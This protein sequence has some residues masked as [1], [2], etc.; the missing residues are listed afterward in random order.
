MWMRLTALSSARLDDRRRL[1]Y[2][3]RRAPPADGSSGIPSHDHELRNRLVHD[4]ASAHD[5]TPTDILHHNGVS[6]DPA[7]V[8]DRNALLP[9]LLQRHRNVGP[10][11]VDCWIG[12]HSVVM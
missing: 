9:A 6:A 1:P 2:P 11:D 3:R 10:V 8:A 12:A 7:V 4:G 5:H